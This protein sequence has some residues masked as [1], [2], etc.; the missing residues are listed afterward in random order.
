MVPSP[1]SPNISA[2][3]HMNTGIM[4]VPTFLAYVLAPKSPVGIVPLNFTLGSPSDGLSAGDICRFI[5]HL[6]LTKPG[7]DAIKRP[8]N[9]G[10]WTTFWIVE[11]TKVGRLDLEGMPSDLSAQAPVSCTI[12][13]I[14]L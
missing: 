3:V 7:N 5:V 6:A 13:Y 1:V 4:A 11:V 9:G 14:V 10:W 2:L 8:E 12:L